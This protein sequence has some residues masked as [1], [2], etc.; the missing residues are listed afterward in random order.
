MNASASTQA[1][2]PHSHAENWVRVPGLHPALSTLADAVLPV[3]RESK[4]GLVGLGAL[5]VVPGR[6]G[7]L[8]ERAEVL[9]E[10]SSH[11]C[12]ELART[13][14]SAVAAP[15]AGAVAGF[16]EQLGA[17]AHVVALAGMTPDAADGLAGAY[18]GLRTACEPLWPCELAPEGN[19]ALPT[20]VRRG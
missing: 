2:I 4:R 17:W 14:D 15:L 20:E 7:E 9:A 1:A 5:A 8:R 10:R 6:E 13:H 16:L 19:L 18:R 3:L 12:E 11:W